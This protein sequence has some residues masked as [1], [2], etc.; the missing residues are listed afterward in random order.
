MNL[1]IVHNFPLHRFGDGL[2]SFE[3]PIDSSIDLNISKIQLDLIAKGEIGYRFSNE[4]TG[5]NGL[6]ITGNS[7]VFPEVKSWTV[8]PALY[9]Y[10]L[11]I[12][13]VSGFVYTYHVG[14]W[15]V[16]NSLLDTDN[17]GYEIPEIPTT[18]IPTSS[19]QTFIII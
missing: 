10:E 9:K 1:P 19:D 15:P 6:T 17:P 8:N 2:K 18:Y 7:I 13:D 4:L 16:L 12:T 11:K 14:S 5:D 3:L